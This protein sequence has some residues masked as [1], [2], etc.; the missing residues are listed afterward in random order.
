MLAVSLT[1]WRVLLMNIRGDGR[2]YLGDVVSLCV[3]RCAG[4]CYLELPVSS[5]QL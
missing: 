2:C 5:P 3:A 1:V 4:D